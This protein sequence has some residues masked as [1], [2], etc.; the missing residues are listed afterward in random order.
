M[1]RLVPPNTSTN[2]SSPGTLVGVTMISF[3]VC[4]SAFMEI[5]GTWRNLTPP[6]VFPFWYLGLA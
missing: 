2:T 4:G 5:S 3:P 6:V 1:E